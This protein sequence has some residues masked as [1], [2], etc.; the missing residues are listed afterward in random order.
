[1]LVAGGVVLAAAVL[2]GAQILLSRPAV[3]TKPSSPS[4]GSTAAT[5]Q[6]IPRMQTAETRI[7][8][9]R[10]TAPVPA[11][12]ILTPLA[13]APGATISGLA[14]DAVPAG[15]SYSIRMRPYGFGPS[16]NLGTQLVIRVDSVSAGPQA[17]GA[18]SIANANLLV[19]VDT[20]H[21]GAVT[22]GGRYSA[23]LTFR[24][25]GKRLVPV[26]SECKGLE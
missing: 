4:A 25:D 8:S 11:G 6:P 26:L 2:V 17:D 3:L 18:K 24:S 22:R 12:V 13:D 14:L 23:T 15:A 7:P 10:L 21:G 9:R 1:M 20:L 16:S 5:L 19:L